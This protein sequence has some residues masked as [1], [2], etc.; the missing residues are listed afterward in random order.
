MRGAGG[1][2]ESRARQRGKA[3]RL[4]ALHRHRILGHAGRFARRRPAAD[5]RDGRAEASGDAAGRVS[6]P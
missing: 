6:R 5:T 2:A 3:A 4:D 1:V